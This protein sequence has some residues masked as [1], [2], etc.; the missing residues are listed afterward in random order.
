[1]TDPVHITLKKGSLAVTLPDPTRYDP[2]YQIVVEHK[3]QGKVVRSEQFVCVRYFYDG[4]EFREWR[5]A[6]A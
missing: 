6:D 5:R 3:D 1:M 2:G 4:E